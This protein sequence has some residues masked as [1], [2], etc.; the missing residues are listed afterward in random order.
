MSSCGISCYAWNTCCVSSWRLLTG[1]WYDRIRLPISSQTCSVG[2][3]SGDWA[4][5]SRIHT[6][7]KV[8]LVWTAVW[9]LALSS[10]NMP[11]GALAMKGM[12]TGF[13]ILITYWQAFNL[14]S[15]STNSALLYPYSSPHL[16]SRSWRVLHQQSLLPVTFHQVVYGHWRRSDCHKQKRDPLLNT[17][18]CHSNVPFDYGSTPSKSLLSMIWCQP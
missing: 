16:D 17:T 13:T 8:F 6:F 10:W 15:A 1:G 9:G 14:L 2:D 18:E 7:S 4:G 11:F 5:Q 12:T 3:K